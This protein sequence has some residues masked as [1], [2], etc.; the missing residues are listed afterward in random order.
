MP[1]TF[2]LF[3]L[4]L[5]TWFSEVSG[6]S[7]MLFT[8]VVVGSIIGAGAYFT[9]IFAKIFYGGEKSKKVTSSELVVDSLRE[10]LHSGKL[11]DVV[12]VAMDGDRE[13]AKFKA[14]KTILAMRCEYFRSMFSVG[15]KESIT[16]RVPI[17]ASREAVW[18]LL[19]FIYCGK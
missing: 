16:S 11:S 13:L 15:M 7:P 10:L 4:C 6:I 19:K 2:A 12:I 5:E 3:C 9:S 18:Q 14:H 8:A 17:E 1:P